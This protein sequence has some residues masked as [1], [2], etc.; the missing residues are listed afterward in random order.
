MM[1]FVF[2]FLQFR[3]VHKTRKLVEVEH[4]VVL[5]VL[6][7]EGHILAEVHILEMIRDKASIAALDALGKLLQNVRLVHWSVVSR[8]SSVVSR[9]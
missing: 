2:R 9:Q 3:R 8:Q 1:V 7:K 5:A 6:A 4:R